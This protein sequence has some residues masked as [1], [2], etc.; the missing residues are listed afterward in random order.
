MAG[1]IG[2][3]YYPQINPKCHCTLQPWYVHNKHDIF[4]TYA[5]HWTLFNIQHI[6]I[7]NYSL[8]SLVF[9]F[10]LTLAKPSN[11]GWIGGLASFCNC[12]SS[13]ISISFSLHASFSRGKS[14]SFFVSLIRFLYFLILSPT[15][16]KFFFNLGLSSAVV[17]SHS[18]NL[19][20]QAV[21][22]H[23]KTP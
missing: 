16:K 5:K 18:N 23:L 13:D 2:I 12:L 1:K 3:E 22:F 20:K 17:S 8:V 6:F 14:S 10:F 9:C 7:I 11:A 19:F 15:P 4:F 21:S